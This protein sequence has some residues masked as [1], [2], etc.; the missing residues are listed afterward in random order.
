MTRQLSTLLSGGLPLISALS[1]LID[2]VENPHLKK[3]IT[4]VREMVSEGS[5]LT[6]AMAQ[7]SNVFSELYVNM[8]RAGEASGTLDIIFLRLADFAEGQVKM[9]NKIRTALAYPFFMLLFGIAVVFFLV[10]FVIPRV[11]DIFVDM[12]Q[13]LPLPTVILIFLS[14]TFKQFWWMILICGVA[15]F[16]FVRRYART[17]KG[18]ER[19]DRLKI[20]VPLFGDLIQKIYVSRFSKTLGTLLESGIPI[21]VSLDIVKNVVN[22]KIIAQSIEEAKENIREGEDISSP[23][24]RTKMFPP[25]VTHMLAIGEKSGNIETMLSKISDAYDNEVETRI[26]LLTSMLEPI[27]ILLMGLIVLFIVLSVLLPIF[28]I[29]QMIR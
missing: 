1:A 23:L 20:N 14:D 26:S 19:F 24:K 8:V 4:S 3:V 7:H 5:S 25:M 6:D 18:R 21:V 12:Q 28:E 9:M 17:E 29:N 13:K 22:N 27:M 16:I 15:L 10:T 2:Q 11:T